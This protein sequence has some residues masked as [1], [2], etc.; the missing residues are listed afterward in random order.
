MERL[1]QIIA[2]ALKNL[3]GDNYLLALIVAQR[4]EQLA[5]GSE[6]LLSQDY[7]NKHHI[8]KPVDIAIYEIA[9]DKLDFK[10]S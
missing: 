9:E 8:V 2:K 6:P 1:E 10:L 5:R 3:N 4:S 7:L